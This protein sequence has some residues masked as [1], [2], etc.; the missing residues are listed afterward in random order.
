[1]QS[2]PKKETENVQAKWVRPV[3]DIIPDPKLDKELAKAK[4]RPKSAKFRDRPHTLR[5]APVPAHFS[6]ASPTVRQNMSG[7]DITI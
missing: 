7:N 5:T 4:V 3:A 2:Q 1:M 6:Q